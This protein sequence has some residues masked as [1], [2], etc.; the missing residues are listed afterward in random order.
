MTLPRPV[1]LIVAD[2]GRYGLW[3]TSYLGS[4]VL[5][6]HVSAYPDL[7]LRL[8]ADYALGGLWRHRSEIGEVIETIGRAGRPIL[9]EALVEAFRRRGCRAV[10]VSLRE[11]TRLSGEYAAFGW[12]EIGAMVFYRFAPNQIEPIPFQGRIRDVTAADLPEVV[13]IDR[14]SFDWLWQESEE[15]LRSYLEEPG[16]LF[17]LAEADGQ[18][19]GY[20]AANFRARAANFDRLGVRPTLGG[21]GVGRGLLT[22]ALAHF[23]RLGMTEL[24]LNTQAGNERS[25]RLYQRVGFV[26]I[27]EPRPLYGRLDVK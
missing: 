22:A 5:R 3:R 10:V 12:P 27:G 20:L 4:Q 2:V 7:C 16:R 13:E 23:R 15:S 11:S 24:T 19:A 14:L 26:P 9:L 25:R 17:W 8:G 1:P 18:I 6:A 21:R